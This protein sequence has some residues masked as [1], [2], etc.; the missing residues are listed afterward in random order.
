MP[1]NLEIINNLCNGIADAKSEIRKSLNEKFSDGTVSG[2]IPIVKKLATYS[3]WVEDNVTYKLP[4]VEPNDVNFFDYDGTLRYSY[5]KTEFASLTELPPLPQHPGLI[6]QEWNWTLADA[7]TEVNTTGKLNIGLSCVPTDGKT[8]LFIRIDEDE[9]NNYRSGRVHVL[10]GDAEYAYDVT[11]NWF[12]WYASSTFSIDWGDGSTED[13][14]T[15]LTA[16][17]LQQTIHWYTSPGNYVISLSATGGAVGLGHT[18]TRPIFG[19]TLYA[20]PTMNYHKC[21]ILYKVW[22]GNDRINVRYHTFYYQNNLEAIAIPA[23]LEFHTQYVFSKCK[24]LKF[25]VFPNSTYTQN[26]LEGFGECYGLKGVSISKYVNKINGSCFS[27]CRSLRYFTPTTYITTLNSTSQFLNCFILPEIKLP[28]GVTTIPNY[29]F[30]ECR[31]LK[32]VDIPSGVTSMGTQVFNNNYSL[33]S[34][35]LNPTTPPTIQ[36]NTFSNMPSD[37]KYYVPILSWAKYKTASNWSNI[38]TTNWASHTNS[39]N[40]LLP[41]DIPTG[42]LIMIFS[43]DSLSDLHEWELNDYASY[44]AYSGEGQYSTFDIHGVNQETDDFDD[45]IIYAYDVS[46]GYS[47]KVFD[48]PLEWNYVNSNTPVSAYFEIENVNSNGEAIMVRI[49]ENSSE[50]HQGTPD[51]KVFLGTSYES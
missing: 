34:I 27:Y 19:D 36:S 5:T 12:P 37:V 3:D 25:V 1:T 14:F 8:K 42:K 51:T 24:N 15:G 28:S 49:Y 23:T 18:N 2:N 48:I 40:N 7:K 10:D 13:T 26:S 4:E 17:S 16:N 33:K 22:L 43:Y 46:N 29:I 47:M 35:T 45:L 50:P 11:L 31:N 44:T 39:S 38:F 41:F 21:S 6:S 30:N 9:F 20:E 32:T